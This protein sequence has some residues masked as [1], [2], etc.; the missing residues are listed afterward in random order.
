MNP[1]II[2]AFSGGLDTSFCVAHLKEQGYEVITVTVNTGGFGSE[3]LEALEKKA[4]SLG[5]SKHYSIDAEEKIYSQ[6]ISHLIR[7]D[8]LYEG[9]YPLMCADRY[10]IAEE[11]L[12]IAKKENASFV[13]HG[14]TSVGNDQ[15]R[16]DSALLT[17]NPSIQILCP[18]KELAITRAQEITYLESKGFAVSKGNK[19]YSINQN[20]FGV[21]LS[22]SEIDAYKE[23]SSDA[24]QLTQLTQKNPAYVTLEFEQGLPITLNGIK[25]NGLA[26]LK[27]IN[28]LVGA[29]GI[30]RGSYT[31]DCIIGIKGHIVFEAP[32]LFALL[33]A[34]KKLQQVTLTKKQLQFHALASAQWADV[35]YSGL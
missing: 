30:G 21:T 16:F 13:S 11:V 4:L 26:I 25:K 6:I 9:E 20:V 19:Q 27:E 24:Y 17:L 14:S 1:K 28:T 33:E 35:V 22:G 31:G 12:A 18:I 29:F 7:L 34:H 32:G 5:S 2:L 15:V 10:I 8:G 23:P 3:T